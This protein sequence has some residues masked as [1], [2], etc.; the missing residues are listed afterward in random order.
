MSPIWYF[1]HKNRSVVDNINLYIF[2]S[3]LYDLN[4]EFCDVADK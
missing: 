4:D 1:K 2:Y 3:S